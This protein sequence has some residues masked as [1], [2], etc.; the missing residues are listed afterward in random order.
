MNFLREGQLCN[1]PRRNKMQ[2]DASVMLLFGG[3]KLLFGGAKA[4][5]G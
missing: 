1:A 3:A 4:R 2:L 5:V